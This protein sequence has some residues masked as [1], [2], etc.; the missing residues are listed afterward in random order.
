MTIGPRLF[1]YTE[2]DLEVAAIFEPPPAADCTNENDEYGDWISRLED[3]AAGIQFMTRE[4]VTDQSADPLLLGLE[5]LRLQ[6]NEIEQQMILLVA[7]MRENIKPRPYTLQQI[8]DAAGL[9]VSG[10]RTFYDDE[11]VQILDK[12]IGY[13]KKTIA[14]EH[15]RRGTTPGKPSV[16]LDTT[17]NPGLALAQDGTLARVQRHPDTAAA[18]PDPSDQT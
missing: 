1:G 8:A 11:D 16:P 14:D 7:Y 12:R 5:R 6:R 10:T 9:S 15:I 4:H 2:A 13:A 3:R 18:H 17:A